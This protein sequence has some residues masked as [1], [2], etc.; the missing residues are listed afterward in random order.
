MKFPLVTTHW[1]DANLYNTQLVLIDVSMSKVVG[2][3]AIEYKEPLFIPGSEHLDVETSLC[4]V[5]SAQVHAFPTEQQFT[6]TAQ[7][8]G[9]NSD[10][11]VVLYDNQGIY[12]APRVWWI[13]KAMGCQNVFVLDGG[14][15]Q[16]LLEKRAVVSA[17][18]NKILPLGNI[19]GKLQSGFVCNAN[20]IIENITSELITVLD[21]R[22][23]ERF[24]GLAPEPRAGVRSG[25][26]PGSINLPF[27]QVLNGHSF[28]STEQLSALFSSLL[29]GKKS[30]LIFSCG[31]GITACIILL[32]A[33]IAGYQNLVLYDGS[34]SDWGSDLSLPVT[35]S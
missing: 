20:Y 8:L 2:K 9:I 7:Q 10:S 5:G 29:A 23:K 15:P 14:L 18:S 24:F 22:A 25:H 1:L 17:P 30:Q 33:V 16:W 28:K 13:F 26:I 27:S 11:T 31:S 34:W 32:A 19:I 35:V 3:T 21:A 12:S 6:F 4:D